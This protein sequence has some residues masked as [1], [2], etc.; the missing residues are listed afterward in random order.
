VSNRILKQRTYFANCDKMQQV[1]VR[2]AKKYECALA[3]A[4]LDRMD[5]D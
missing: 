3:G 1:A 4:A 2:L 5:M